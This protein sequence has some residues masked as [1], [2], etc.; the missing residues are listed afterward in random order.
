MEFFFIF[1]YV[2]FIFAAW[3]KIPVKLYMMWIVAVFSTIAFLYDPFI[4]ARICGGE[5]VDL[6]RHFDSLDLIRMGFDEGVYIEAPLSALYFKIIAY[7]FEKNN[8]LPAISVLIYYYGIFFTFDNFFKM[9]NANDSIQRFVICMVLMCSVFFD[10]MNNIRYPL[11]I[12]MF[13]IGLYLETVKNYKLSV[14]LYCLSFFMHPGIIILIIVRCISFIKLKYGIVFLTILSFIISNYFESLVSI[15]I[16]LLSSLPDLQVLLLA[17]SMKFSNYSSNVVYEVPL[18][19]KLLTLYMSCL[20]IVCYIF[21]KYYGEYRDEFKYIY[22]MTILVALL[23]IWG[24]TTNYMDG[25]FSGRIMSISPLFISLLVAD[26]L[27]NF[28]AENKNYMCLKLLFLIFSMPHIV[29]YLF[30]VYPLWIYFGL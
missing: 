1:N 27:V 29:V 19:F 15:S 12:N 2:A 25:N 14:F 3:I 6:C 11:A 9:L 8:F 24:I 21:N 20:V 28:P 7:L 4:Q 30:I 17:I 5:G 23:S 18:E 26:T 22:R 13:F 16:S 10:V